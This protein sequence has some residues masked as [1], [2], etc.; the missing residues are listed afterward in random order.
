MGITNYP[1][2]LRKNKHTRKEN[3]CNDLYIKTLVLKSHNY[4]SNKNHDFL[5]R[6]Q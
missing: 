5:Y 3:L 2:L 4:E 1:T 6:V